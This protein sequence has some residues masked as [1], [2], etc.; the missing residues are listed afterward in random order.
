MTRAMFLDTSAWVSAAVRT[1]THHVAALAA[2]TIAVRQGYRIVITPMVLGESHALF[3]RL[4]G[5]DKARAAIGAVQRDPTHVVL[6][7]DADLV[8]SAT[9]RWIDGY[10]DQQFSLCDAV[11]FEIMKREGITRA[12]SVDKHF[13]TAGFEVIG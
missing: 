7:V 13:L 6:P 5:R 4:L 1:Q 2:Y 11:S 12:L 3:L 10:G 8:V 9:A